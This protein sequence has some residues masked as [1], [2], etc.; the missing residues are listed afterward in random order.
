MAKTKVIALEGNE[1]RASTLR[2]IFEASGKYELVVS[3]S[4]KKLADM[5]DG[6]DEISAVITNTEISR[7]VDDGLKFIKILYLKYQRY[8]IPLPPILVCSADQR[9]DTI[10]L[11][12]YRFADLALIYYVLIKDDDLKADKD[13]LL[14]ILE[15]ALAKRR[16]LEEQNPETKAKVVKEKIKGLLKKTITLPS[17]PDVAIR[18]QDSLKDPDITMK[19]LGRHHQ[20]RYDAERQP[21]QA[22]QQSP[23]RSVGENRDHRRRLYSGWSQR[24][25]QHRHGHKGVRSPGHHFDMKRLRHSFAV[26]TIT[27][28]VARRCHALGNTQQQIQ[29]SGT[30][31]AAGLLHD[32]GKVLLVEYFGDEV[33]K[34]VEEVQVKNCHMVEAETAVL[35][36]SH[37]DAGFHAGVEW[38]FPVTLV[39]VIARHHWPLEQILPRLKSKTGR[40]AQ[41]VIRIADAVSYEMG[42]DMMRADGTPPPVDPELFQKTG[43]AKQDFDKWTKEIK[44]DI[45]YTLEVLGGV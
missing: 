33:D 19:K 25:C 12:A 3:N 28:I 7:A 34:I 42:Y 31:F 32:I 5:M 27:R 29:F 11:Y 41:R 36:I 16:E 18:V 6:G 37:A 4:P 9:G 17:L 40:L 14:N 30:M 35:G 13:K 15:K 10:K 45:A 43:I 38:K 44:D 39:N 22:G 1:D 24:H 26:G 8:A 2:E 20:H 23:V 21:D